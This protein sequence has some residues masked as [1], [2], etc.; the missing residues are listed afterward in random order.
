MK[1]GESIEHNLYIKCSWFSFCKSDKSHSCYG[2]QNFE[3]I[4]IRNLESVIVRKVY[5]LGS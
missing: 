1:V 4:V 5:K 2:S 3:N